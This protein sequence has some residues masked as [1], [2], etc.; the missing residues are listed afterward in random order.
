MNPNPDKTLP[1]AAF[2]EALGADPDTLFRQA[3]AYCNDKSTPGITSMLESEY[4]SYNAETVTLVMAFPCLRWEVSPR[5][6]MMGGIV[7]TVFDAAM[8]MLTGYVARGQYVTT[9]DLTTHFIKPVRLG[10]TLIV[11]TQVVSQG[12]TILNLRSTARAQSNGQ[13]LASAE[14]AFMI[15]K[16][17]PANFKG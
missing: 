5:D 10:E 11:E 12:K 2:M 14:A 8:G 13:L 9:L 15:V 16:S 3:V 6:N 7:T 1:N 17:L 4:I